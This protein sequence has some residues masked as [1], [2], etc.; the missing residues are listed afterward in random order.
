MGDGKVPLRLIVHARQYGPLPDADN[1]I[2]AMKAYQDGIADALGINDRHFSAPTVSFSDRRT[3]R[4]VIEVG[5]LPA[6][7]G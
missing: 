7:N 4:F 1:C 2:A 5:S 3:G 6:D